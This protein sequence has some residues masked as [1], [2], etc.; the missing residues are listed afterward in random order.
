MCIIYMHTFYTIDYMLR[1]NLI[2][3]TQVSANNEISLL[4]MIT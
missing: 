1:E 4:E 2:A 3:G